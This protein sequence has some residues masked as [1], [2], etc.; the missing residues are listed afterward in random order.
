M[1]NSIVGALILP[2]WKMILYILALALAIVTVRISVK[3]D[4]NAWL[5]SGKIA[6]DNKRRVVDADN[7]PHLWTVYHS[8]PYSRCNLC[9]AWIAT[10]TL[11]L[12]RVYFEPKPI[13]AGESYSLL[14]SPQPNEVVVGDYIG[15]KSKV[16]MQKSR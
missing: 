7:C 5:Q 16:Q 9:Q 8:S 15:A 12:A 11:L 4:V 13:I 14:V 3:F 1:D 6:K 2:W 10:S